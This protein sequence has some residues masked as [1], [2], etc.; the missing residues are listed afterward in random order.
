MTIEAQIVREA[1]RAAGTEYG[2]HWKTVLYW[3][4]IY[5]K[6]NFSLSWTSAARGHSTCSSTRRTEAQ[7]DTKWMVRH[8]TSHA[9]APPRHASILELSC[10]QHALCFEFDARRGGV[11]SPATKH[12]FLADRV[13][14][15]VHFVTKSRPRVSKNT[16]K[17]IILMILFTKFRTDSLD[18]MRRGSNV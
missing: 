10:P 1:A 2:F 11:L 12:F 16:E 6:H 18:H 15:N 4:Q 5:R 13:C 8:A 14:K 17:C 9:C 3:E 7:I